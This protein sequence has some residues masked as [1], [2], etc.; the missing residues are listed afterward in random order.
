MLSGCCLVG[1]NYQGKRYIKKPQHIKCIFS[2]KS[3][4]SL[5]DVTPAIY[6]NL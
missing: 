2:G 6:L 3:E 4:D 5:P 1:L